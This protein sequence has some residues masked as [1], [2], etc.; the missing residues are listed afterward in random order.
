MVARAVSSSV[1]FPTP[2]AGGR[3][4]SLDPSTFVHKQKRPRRVGPLPLLRGR[5]S[6]A[7][8]A[9]GLIRGCALCGDHPAARPLDSSPF[10]WFTTTLHCQAQVKPLETG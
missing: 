8:A 9:S 7:P 5:D 1:D 4:P 2:V 10:R 3:E 6:G